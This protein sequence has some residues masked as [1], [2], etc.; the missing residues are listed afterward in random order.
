MY[1]VSHFLTYDGHHYTWN[2]VCNY[3]L[4]QQGTNY[5][6]DVGVFTDFERCWGCGTCPSHTIYR[7]DPHTLVKITTDALFDVSYLDAGLVLTS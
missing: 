2:G 6:T 5:N 3:T 7:N 4:T 1:S